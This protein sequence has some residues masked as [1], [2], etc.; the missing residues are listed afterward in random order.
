MIVSVC[1]NTQG[2]TVFKKPV[3][4][5]LTVMPT[6]STGNEGS[7]GGGET[8]IIFDGRTFTLTFSHTGGMSLESVTV[9]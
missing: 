8:A 7:G 1:V 4:L 6:Q 5:H 3:K 9:T 2:K